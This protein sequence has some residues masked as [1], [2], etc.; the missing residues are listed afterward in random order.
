MKDCHASHAELGPA[1]KYPLCARV[2]GDGSGF[3][4]Q[5]LVGGSIDEHSHKPKPGRVFGPWS[6]IHRRPIA[7]DRY[8]FWKLCDS[9]PVFKDVTQPTSPDGHQIKL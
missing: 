4:S 3:L 2:S 6:S 1:T 7:R 9:P 5:L 8:E